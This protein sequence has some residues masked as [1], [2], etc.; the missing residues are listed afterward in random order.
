MEEN[1]AIKNYTEWINAKGI[2]S[3]MRQYLMN[4]ISRPE[5][6]ESCFSEELDFGTAG[7]RATMGVGFAH[8]ICCSSNCIDIHSS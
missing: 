6:I 8:G 1:K 4:M 3:D 2:D 5:E 7:M